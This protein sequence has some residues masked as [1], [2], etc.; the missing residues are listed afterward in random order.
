[1]QGRSTVPRVDCATA[2]SQAAPEEEQ[3]AKVE[4]DEKYSHVRTVLE[5]MLSDYNRFFGVCG[6]S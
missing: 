6:T 5:I 3:L 2:L 4:L 1:M